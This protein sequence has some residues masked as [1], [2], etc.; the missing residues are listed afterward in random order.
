MPNDY[1]PEDWRSTPSCP[2]HYSPL[3]PDG[4]CLH[5]RSLETAFKLSR[6]ITQPFQ[7]LEIEDDEDHYEQP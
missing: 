4:S 6:E 1:D 3:S 7:P 5:C 2:V